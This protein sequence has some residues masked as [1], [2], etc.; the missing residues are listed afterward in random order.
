[1]M[2][3]KFIM[4]GDTALHVADSDRGERCVVLVHGYLE[5]MYVWDDFVPLLTPHVRVVTVDVPGHG[6]SQVLGEV[7]TMEMM[8]DVLHGMLDALGI[9]RATFVGHSMGGYISLAFC[10]KYPERM[11]GL[12]LLSSSPCPDDETKRENRRREI[13]LVRAGKKD[14]LAHV[15]PETGFA[16][17]NRERLKDYL[18]DLVEQVHVTEDE[19]IVALLGGMIARVDQNAML[20]ASRVPQLF[21]LGRHDNYIPVE[22]AERFVADNPQAQVVWLEASGHMGFIEE[23]ERCA[24]AILGFVL[25]GDA[26]AFDNAAG[27]AAGAAAGGGKEDDAPETDDQTD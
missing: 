11:D 4:A 17:Q 25:R 27:A 9:G 22:A 12:V 20:R 2:K 6:V 8:A 15:A 10:A 5:S 1:M 23:P 13:A 21:R 18:D 3:E 16:V 19:G 24:A 7:H 14:V 26:R